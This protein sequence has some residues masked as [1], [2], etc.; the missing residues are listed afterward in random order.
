MQC[1]QCSSL[2]VELVPSRLLHEADIVTDLPGMW[3]YA[4]MFPVS[5]ESASTLAQTL[6]T[7]VQIAD[8][9]ELAAVL[10]VE[11][12]W[13]IAFV[14]GPSGTFKDVEG[15]LV[16]AKCLDW[17]LQDSELSWHS[18]GNTARAYRGYALAAG[19]RSRSYFPLSCISKWRGVVVDR[20]ASLVAYDGGYA[21]VATAA[22]AQA[23][24]RGSRHLT[25]FRWKLEGKAPMAYVIADGC[26][27]VTAISQTIAGGYG[28]L[29]MHLGYRR[30]M[31]W[32]LMSVG[33]PRYELVQIRGA[34]TITQ[35]LP[36]QG[37]ITIDDIRLPDEPFEPTLQSTNPLSTLGAV[38]DLISTTGSSIT[39]VSET[40]VDA[41]ADELANACASHGIAVSFDDEKSPFIGWAG[42]VSRARV[43]GL[44]QDDRI[45]FVVTGSPPRTGESPAPDEVISGN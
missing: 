42:L 10:G 41:A 23:E 7:D 16:V 15:A 39:S 45:A 3:R 18:T 31:R 9:P 12:V 5:L 1:P 35:L 20:D 4:G 2:N 8:A 6:T 37:P 26:E 28:P 17:G 29:G 19:F 30:L 36:S 44:A 43:H 25:P 11:K 34:D 27:G 33:E 38:R 14:G 21:G 22:R 24:R 13:L 32:N 40:E